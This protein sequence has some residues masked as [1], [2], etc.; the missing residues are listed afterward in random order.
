MTIDGGGQDG[1][2]LVIVDST[3]NSGD[4]FEITSATI[5]DSGEF[6]G[7]GDIRYQGLSRFELDLA[8]N[9]HVTA[10][11]DGLAVE[12]AVRFA[13]GP[14]NSLT[15]DGSE[16]LSDLSFDLSD[17]NDGTLN[18]DGG[19]VEFQG[20][21]AIESN[22]R[23]SNLSIR[24]SDTDDSIRIDA[25]AGADQMQFASDTMSLTVA[26]PSEFLA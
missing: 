9:S 1:D 18:V 14:S 19:I 23:A 21:T 10:N 26:S 4:T 7:G 11:L 8:A 5:S 24:W 17:P 15:L 2:R 13:D 3:D 25:V 12:V 16:E 20:T 6:L 22:L